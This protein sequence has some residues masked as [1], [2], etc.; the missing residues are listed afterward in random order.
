M[1]SI[2]L[3]ALP[4]RKFTTGNFAEDNFMTEEDNHGHRAKKKSMNRKSN[5]KRH[6]F[7]GDRFNENLSGS[8]PD[9]TVKAP[10]ASKNQNVSKQQT[11]SIR[12]FNCFSTL[13]CF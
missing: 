6:G 7:N 13:I 10:K 3:K 8:A 11:L 5:K 2:G 9:K 12:W 4:L 1:V